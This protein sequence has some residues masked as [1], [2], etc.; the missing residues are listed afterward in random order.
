[1]SKS[2]CYSLFGQNFHLLPQK[3]AFWEERQTL[4][5]ADV[6]LGKAGHFRKAGLAVPQQV[7]LQDLVT[8]ELI[9]E[10]WQPAKILI[11]G[12]LFHSEW[13]AEWWLFTEWLENFTAI[14]WTLV[15][16]NH[17]V[18]P[19]TVY[20]KSILKVIPEQQPLPP[21]LFTHQPTDVAQ[22][23]YNISGHVHPSVRLIGRGRQ[24]I[25]L[26]CF[27]FGAKK[28]IL[29]AFGKFTGTATIQPQSG[30]AVF[31]ISSEEVIRVC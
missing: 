6:H 19:A 15:R 7:H 21:F 2:L 27:Y 4:I 29:P 16:G 14:E 3:A 26:P 17:D 12:D 18:L 8:L 24:S 9:I 10:R 25:V 20:Q 13:N 31:V 30:D 23:W 22:E 5:L 11:I 28:G 1:M